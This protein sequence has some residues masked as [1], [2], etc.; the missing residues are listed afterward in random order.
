MI[1]PDA[2]MAAL[3]NS[4]YPVVYNKVTESNNLTNALMVAVDIYIDN[5]RSGRLPEQLPAGLPKDLFSGKDFKYEK[6]NGGFILRCQGKDLERDKF[7]EYEFK[8]KK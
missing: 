1:N 7:N 8:V 6:T 3:I 5:A 4:P 2:T